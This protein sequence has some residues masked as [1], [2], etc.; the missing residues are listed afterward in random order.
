MGCLAP[1]DNATLSR[2]R[3]GPVCL[4]A[5]RHGSA[6]SV[7]PGDTPPLAWR[8]A[9]IAGLLRPSASP[10]REQ[11]RR[12]TIKAYSRLVAG[13]LAIGLLAIWVASVVTLP[14]SALLAIQGAYCAS[15]GTFGLL[16]LR[17]A[18]YPRLDATALIGA[19]LVGIVL[20]F[21][22]PGRT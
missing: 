13:G 17:T 19:G 11:L 20:T 10:Q 21:L 16:R 2:G 6:S 8:P 9:T 3:T 12:R 22:V 7:T 4:V 14:R 5:V 1:R 15:I 18:G